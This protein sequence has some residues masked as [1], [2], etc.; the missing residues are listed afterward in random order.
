MTSHSVSEVLRINRLAVFQEMSMYDPAP[1]TTMF[2]CVFLNTNRRTKTVTK[3][4]HS[5]LVK[6]GPPINVRNTSNKARP[7]KKIFMRPSSLGGGRI[8]RRTLS[9]CPSVCPSVPLSSVTSRHLA[10]Y[11]DTLRAAYRTAISA[12]QTCFTRTAAS[13]RRNE[14]EF[15]SRRRAA[16]T[17]GTVDIP[18]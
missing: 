15:L 17:S 6:V 13:G 5:P 9:V 18:F 4:G 2:L 11:N 1:S 8:L 10:N 12:A 3:T 7:R 16:E 14:N